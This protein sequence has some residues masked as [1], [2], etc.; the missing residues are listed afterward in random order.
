MHFCFFLDVNCPRTWVLAK[1]YILDQSLCLWKPRKSPHQKTFF[2]P[3]LCSSKRN[4]SVTLAALFNK[5]FFPR[6]PANRKTCRRSLSLPNSC[7]NSP[8]SSKFEGRTTTTIHIHNPQ[9]FDGATKQQQQK[10]IRQRLV[11]H[12]FAA[13]PFSSIGFRFWYLRA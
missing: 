12:C 4:R 9:L 5:F 11:Y 3:S 13:L 10:K 6:S 7:C 8:Y 1:M 2:F